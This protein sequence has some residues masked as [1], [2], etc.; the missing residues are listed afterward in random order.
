MNDVIMK[1]MWKKSKD[2]PNVQTKQ[3][4]MKKRP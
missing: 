3:I 1:K 2:S 4:Q